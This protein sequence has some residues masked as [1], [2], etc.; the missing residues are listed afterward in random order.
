MK[1]Q[2]PPQLKLICR[3]C[4]NLLVWADCPNCMGVGCYEV[5]GERNE[6]TTVGCGFCLGDGGWN[7]CQKC[8]HPGQND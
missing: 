7:Y 6:E 5:D 8:N 4:G 1:E 3:I 2:I